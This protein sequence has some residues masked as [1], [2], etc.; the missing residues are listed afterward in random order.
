MRAIAGAVLIV[1]GAVCVSG[2]VGASTRTG[3]LDALIGI[4]VLLGL[5]GV[6]L[7]LVGLFTD[8]SQ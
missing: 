6:V 5:F 2:A 1:A 3:P 7:L 4:G 8:R